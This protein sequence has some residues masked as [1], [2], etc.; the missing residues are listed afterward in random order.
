M[1][2][3]CLPHC[4]VLAH[5]NKIGGIRISLSFA[6]RVCILT[7]TSRWKSWYSLNPTGMISKLIAMVIVLGWKIGVCVGFSDKLPSVSCRILHI[8]NNNR[9]LNAY[10]VFIIFVSFLIFKQMLVVLLLR[11]FSKHV[12]V[13]N[14][15]VIDY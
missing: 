2:C 4:L 10:C 11:F 6:L 15:V 12:L 8:V 14:I 1:Y 5:L 7:L 13:S 3:I 9:F